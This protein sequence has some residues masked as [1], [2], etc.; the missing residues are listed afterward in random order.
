MVTGL[1]LPCPPAWDEV[2]N[3]L[4]AGFS[5]LFSFVP[6]L[7]LQQSFCKSLPTH[8]PVP[9]L[10]LHVC[11]QSHALWIEENWS[12]IRNQTNPG[13]SGLAGHWLSFKKK[14]SRLVLQFPYP[15]SHPGSMF[16]ED[17]K[18][19]KHSR[20]AHFK[21][22]PIRLV[23]VNVSDVSIFAAEQV[24]F[25][26]GSSRQQETLAHCC[27]CQSFCRQPCHHPFTAP[28]NCHFYL[29][30]PCSYPQISPLPS[31]QTLYRR[32]APW[33]F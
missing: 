10:W 3:Q 4:T 21:L 24:W 32:H 27:L 17:E 5:V 7:L 30:Y 31:T 2:E 29:L 28:R 20:A 9:G 8:F 22:L 33:T 19:P 23:S 6:N 15:C 13:K 14:D 25:T 12:L 11:A 16:T 26:R 18:L 1:L